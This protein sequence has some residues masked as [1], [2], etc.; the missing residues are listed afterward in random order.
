M[1]PNHIHTQHNWL[2]PI[3]SGILIGTSYIPF[4]PWASLFCFVPLWIFWLQQ[5]QLRFVLLS[6]LLCAFIFTLI[7]FNWVAYMLH[8]FAHLPWFVAIIGLLLFALVAHLFVPLAGVLWFIIQ[9]RLNAG[10]NSSLL[11]MAVLTTICEFYSFTLFDWNFG[12]SWFYSG[13]PLYHWAEFIGFSGL[14][15]ATVLANLAFFSIWQ[16]R[17]SLVGGKQM[18]IFLMLFALLNLSGWWLQKRLATPDTSVNVLLVQA[19]IGNEQKMAAELGEGFRGGILQRYIDL[20][21][22]GIEANGRENLDFI[23]WPETAFPGFLGDRFKRDPLQ[24]KLKNFINQ[25]SVP[26]VTGSYSVDARHHLITNSLYA[27]DQNNN[28]IEPHYSKTILLAFGEYIPGEETFPQLRDW[29]PPIGHFARG[30]GPTMLIKLGD[31]LM[32]PQICYESLFPEFTRGLAQL[33]A[34]FIINVTNDSWYGSWQEP[35]QH[36][37]MTL[38]RAIE[39]RRPVIRAT[40]TGVSTVVLANGKILQLSPIHTQWHGVYHVPYVKHPTAT[41]YQHYFY[42][43]PILL[44]SM[45]TGLLAYAISTKI[46]NTKR[47]E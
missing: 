10:R 26:L 3:I 34:E 5:T 22:E 13:L 28:T 31:L 25:Y 7:G 45:M 1:M 21:I 38:S 2:L 8:E 47:L 4:P 32:G 16:Q 14:S 30:P 18:L 6:G 46:R 36:V 42:L 27:I 39:F 12:Y 24:R 43:V 17:K 35:Y 23:L 41:F 44:W 19:N 11:L 20:S 9:R 37:Y 33:G 15:S 40:N 29:L